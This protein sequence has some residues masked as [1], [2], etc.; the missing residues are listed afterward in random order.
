MRCEKG[1]FV[2]KCLHSANTFE[3]SAFAAHLRGFFMGRVYPAVFA[4]LVLAGHLTGAELYINV[5]LMGSVSLSLLVCYS[6]RPLIVPFLTF[7]FQVSRQNAPGVPSFSDY[8]FEGYRLAI[9]AVSM[10]IVI[11]ALVYFLLRRRCFS[12]VS[13]KRIP[14]LLPLLVFSTALCFNGAFSGRWV[15]SDLI[16]GL[17]Q[18][19]TYTGV[20]LLFYLGL[21]GEDTRAL[22][23]YFVYSSAIVAAVL[24]LEIGGLYL[25][26]DDL[27]AG[28]ELIKG[29]ILFGWGIWNSA[30]SALAVLIPVLFIGAARSKYSLLYFAV[31]TLTLGGI[32]L[33][34]S[35]G[36]LLFGGI[37]YVLSLVA[38]AFVGEH[39]LAYRIILG[40]V[41]TAGLVGAILLRHK[42]P[43]LASGFFAD[44]GRFELWR[45]GLENFASSP[46]FGVGFYGFEYPD[47]PT[48]FKA[49]GFLPSLAHQTFVTLLSGGGIVGLLGYLGYRVSTVIPFFKRPSFEKTMLGASMLVLVGMSLIDNFVFYF[50]QTFHYSIALAIVSLMRDGDKENC[51]S[52][53]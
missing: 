23:S 18:G 32:A 17:L 52:I 28:G 15:A 1:S 42:I 34:M 14:Q 39:R 29:N 44:N 30:G 27:F 47:D 7:V 53:K 19:V 40:V 24:L 33:T 41:V 38:V 36:S 51:H 45:I 9:F 43:E 25:F 26:S 46:I 16:W 2:N 6:A 13:F 11:P 22:T 37:A 50:W 4:L 21:R 48:Y 12:G 20:F 5:I 49:A 35:R 10:A 8:Y 31:A 3:S